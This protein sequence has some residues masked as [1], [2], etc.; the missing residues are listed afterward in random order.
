MERA[1][2]DTG[3]MADPKVVAMARKLRSE[4][5]T[6]QAVGLYVAT[7][8]ASWAAGE[9]L[10]LD[11][12]VPAWWMGSWDD[13]A[14]ALV[15]AKLLGEDRRIPD[16]AW[17]DWYEPARTR[18]DRF[19][20]LGSRGGRATAEGRA[21]ARP[22]AVADAPAEP[23]RTV[24]RTVQP[25]HPSIQPTNQTI[26]PSGDRAGGNGADPLLALLDDNDAI[27]VLYRLTAKVPKQSAIAWVDRLVGEY[28][29]ENVSRM[30][31]VV[32][33]E[34]SDPSTIL[35]RAQNRLWEGA[36]EAGKAREAERVAARTAE[37]ERLDTMT[38]EQRRANMTR[39]RE[40]LATSG[41][42]SREGAEDVLPDPEPK[43]RATRRRRASE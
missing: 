18:R 27:D 25:I 5:T 35:S 10:T 28:G 33:R 8:L 7:V 43:P 13:L 20:T 15:E 36:R 6:M 23:E 30:L 3:L 17:E 21:S 12:A 29:S 24:D 2:M 9:R 37:Q 26:H 4:S 41:L 14:D 16:H 42:M 34:D 22:D 32:H 40:A 19:R 1:D 38:P 11:E 31:A 39:L